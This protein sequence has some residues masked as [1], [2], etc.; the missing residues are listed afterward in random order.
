MLLAVAV[1]TGVSNAGAR[2]FYCEALGLSMTDPCAQASKSE[3]CPTDA[4][5]D[6]DTDCCGV[7]VLPAMPPA[8]R[9][10]SL[11]V[12]RASEVGVRAASWDVDRSALLQQPARDPVRPRWHPPPRSPNEVRSRL[13]VFLT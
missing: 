2:F 12:P 10:A 6:Y 5:T 8:V 3:P 13:M 9:T 7:I 4:L 1:L 11:D